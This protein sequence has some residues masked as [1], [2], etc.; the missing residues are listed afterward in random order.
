MGLAL[1]PADSTQ[2]LPL[3]L[4]FP[5]D[6]MQVGGATQR[7]SAESW[8]FCSGGTVGHLAFAGSYINT[9]MW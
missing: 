8:F 6:R 2:I 9:H 5:G 4:F 7:G 1:G 3:L